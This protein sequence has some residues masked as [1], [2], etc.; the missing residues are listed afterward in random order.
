MLLIIALHHGLPR[1]MLWS[2]QGKQYYHLNT[3]YQMT[4]MAKNAST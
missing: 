4:D 1:E 3:A 2:V